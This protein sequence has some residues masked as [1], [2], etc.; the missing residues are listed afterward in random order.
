MCRGKKAAIHSLFAKAVMSYLS[1]IS[2]L[3]LCRFGYCKPDIQRL[4]G[5]KLIETAFRFETFYRQTTC[6]AAIY[7]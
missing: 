3:Y 7:A 6:Q 5:L 1:L 4:H 2:Y